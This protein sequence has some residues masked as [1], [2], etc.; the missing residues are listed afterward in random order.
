MTIT[1]LKTSEPP[2]AWKPGSAASF[3]EQRAFAKQVLIR[4]WE[5][6][7]ADP[8]N[9]RRIPCI[10]E[11]AEIDP[12]LALQWSAQHGHRYDDAVRRA[13]ARELAE[14]DAPGALALLN[15]KPDSESQ[16]VLQALADRFAETDPKK[17]MPFAEE[18]AVQARGLNQPDRPVA[19]AQ[20]GAVLVKL[21]RA[22]AGR[23]LIDEA[24]R[25]AAQLGTKD[26]A[27]YYR[28]LVAQAAGPLRL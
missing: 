19:M 25:D 5:K 20:A 18:A 27:G 14:T 8:E 15:Q 10:E 1:L 9:N 12:D 22:D 23:K 21:G 24:A 11:M 28:A 26:R 16:S 3:D 4:L 13:Q 17:A 2:P 7:G 6:Y